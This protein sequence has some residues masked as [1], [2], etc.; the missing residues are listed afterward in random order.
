MGYSPQGYKE[1]DTTERLS[2]HA[3]LLEAVL[4]WDPGDLMPRLE[5]PPLHHNL[6]HTQM[7]P[8]VHSP[9]ASLPRY[10]TTQSQPSLSLRNP[11]L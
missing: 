7:W 10:L 11:H 3:H 8:G 4:S 5:V 9:S 2:R 1:L 6:R